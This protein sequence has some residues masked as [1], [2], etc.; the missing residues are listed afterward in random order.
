[1]PGFARLQTGSSLTRPGA[2]RE[3]STV[4]SPAAPVVSVNSSVK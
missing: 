4:D 3:P 1:M 2:K